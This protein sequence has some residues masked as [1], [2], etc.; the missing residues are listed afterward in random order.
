MASI[1]AL[2]GTQHYRTEIRTATRQILA[3]E[4]V[5][6]GG[7]G[8]GFSPEELL[9]ASLGACTSVTLRMYADRKGWTGLKEVKVEVTLSR[10]PE[11]S[12]IAR[13]IELIGDLSAEQRERLL[14]I[15]SKCPMHQ[16]L[17]HPVR[18]DT[19]LK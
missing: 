15:A 14:A 3:D 1:Q 18:I 13:S 2:T 16:V 6:A 9:A 19:A 8:L 4:P 11:Q 5:A 7:Q 10:G 17:T 12:Q